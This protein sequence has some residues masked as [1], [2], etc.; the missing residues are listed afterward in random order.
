[1]RQARR[2][3]LDSAWSTWARRVLAELSRAHPDLPAKTARID[4]MRYGHAMAVPV[5]GV[6]GDPAHRAL[7]P[8]GGGRRLHFAHADL[9]GYSVFEEAFTLGDGAGRAAAASLRVAG[10]SSVPR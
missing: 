2:E 8:A 9:V 1:M 3:L 6:R 10:A 4:L 5:P 7:V